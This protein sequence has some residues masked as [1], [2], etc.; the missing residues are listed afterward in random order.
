LK[1]EYRYVDLN[2]ETVTLLPNELP[3]INELVSAK[4]DPDIQMGRLSINYRFGGNT[5]AAEAA[6][7]K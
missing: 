1:A 3:E 6:P 4:F 5:A 7:L 2:G